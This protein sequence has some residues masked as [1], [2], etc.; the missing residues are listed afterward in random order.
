M[1]MHRHT[2]VYSHTYTYIHMDTHPFI[3]THTL[4]SSPLLLPFSPELSSS[5]TPSKKPLS[6]LT[7]SPGP[8]RPPVSWPRVMLCLLVE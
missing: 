2:P 8:G 1:Y 3:H 4:L 7:W 5:E 6:P